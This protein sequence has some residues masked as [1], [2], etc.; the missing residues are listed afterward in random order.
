MKLKLYY[1][2]TDH[3]DGSAGAKFFTT[4]AEAELYVFELENRGEFTLSEGVD[5]TIIETNHFPIVEE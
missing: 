4:K 3:G 1:I 2:V 5:Y